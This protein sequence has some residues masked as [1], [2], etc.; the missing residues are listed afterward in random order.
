MESGYRHSGKL[1]AILLVGLCLPPTAP[2]QIPS[3][4]TKG[5]DAIKKDVSK[6]K[7]QEKAPNGPEIAPTKDNPQATVAATSGPIAVDQSVS[8]DDVH[9]TLMELLPKD[10]GVRSI[11]VQVDHGLVTLN[12]HIKDEEV[13][14]R[15]TEF[16]RRV[17]GVKLVLNATKTDAQVLTAT[18]L[19]WRVVTDFGRAIS[20]N[21]LLLILAASLATLGFFLARVFNANSETFLAPFVSNP[22]LRSVLG[23][24]IASLLAIGG[25]LLGLSTL[26]LTEAVLSIL[27]LAGVVGLA[28]GFAFRDIAENFIASVLLGLRRPFR[29]GDY[30]QVA[31][32][33][34]VVKTLNTR[35]TVLVTPEGK[36]VRIPNATV[37]KEILINSTASPS[38]RGSFDVLVPHEASTASAL[39]ALNGALKTLDALLPEP[40]PRALVDGIE[41]G[42]I[43]MRTYYWVP[44]SGVDGDKIR[45][46]ALLKAKVALQQAGIVAPRSNV[47]VAIA[48]RLPVDLTQ[49]SD[50]SATDGAAYQAKAN[51]RKDARAAASR[52]GQPTEGRPADPLAHVLHEAEAQVSDEGT[53]LLKPEP[54]NAQ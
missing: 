48:G 51:L 37:F 43:R 46:D 10:P 24:V 22:L 31:G 1:L 4:L 44:S 5:T 13:R 17:E 9:D 11:D 27:G 25:I 12:G 28:L 21:W 36:H 23:S 54:A 39:D 52:D 26:Q 2:G 50:G 33:A 8:D 20:R 34:G 45:S 15:L 41:P 29:V 19:A 40:A 18:E 47:S 14:A 35:A 42:G 49:V 32:H 3:G 6:N 38:V 30:V 16:V 53:N 7:V